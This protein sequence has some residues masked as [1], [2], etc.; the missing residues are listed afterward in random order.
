MSLA[1]VKTKFVSAARTGGICGRVVTREQR[2][3]EMALV[4]DIVREYLDVAVRARC[5]RYREGPFGIVAELERAT[6]FVRPADT[7]FGLR[8]PDDPWPRTVPPPTCLQS[9]GTCGRFREPD[10]W[11]W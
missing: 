9:Q 10:E 1:T 4:G 6:V 8:Y 3:N 7:A 2:R 11:R 5:A